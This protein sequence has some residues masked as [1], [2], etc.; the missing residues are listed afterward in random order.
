MRKTQREIYQV[1]ANEV[2]FT[3]CG[4]CKFAYGEGSCGDGENECHHLLSGKSGFEEQVESAVELGDCWGF[5]PSSPVSF[6]ADIVGIVLAK[7][8]SSVLWWQ[9]KEGIWRVA[10]A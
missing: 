10:G 2:R 8:W 5:R 3:L 1:L 6:C 7:G 4:F 9:D